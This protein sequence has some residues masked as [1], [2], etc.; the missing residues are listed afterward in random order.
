[1]QTLPQDPYGIA[2]VASEQ[3]LV[4]LCSVHATDWTILVPHNI[5]GP[6]Q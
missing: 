4:N 3:T 6:R 1:M 5:V 2:K